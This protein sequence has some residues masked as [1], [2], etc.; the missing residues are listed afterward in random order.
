MSDSAQ[1]PT[2]RNASADF[3]DFLAAHA[4]HVADHERWKRGEISGDEADNLTTGATDLAWIAVGRLIARP[5]TSW[6]DIVELE[7]VISLRLYDK[8][9]RQTHCEELEGALLAAIR[10]MAA[11]EALP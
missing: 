11:K 7:C 9:V 4:Q 10:T 5:V 3:R 6:V 1:F 2:P 8:G